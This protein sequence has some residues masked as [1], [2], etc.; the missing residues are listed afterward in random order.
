MLDLCHE[1]LKIGNTAANNKE[2]RDDRFSTNRCAMAQ[3]LTEDQMKT[4]EV[5]LPPVDAILFI[6]E[7]CLPVANLTSDFPLKRNKSIV[8]YRDAPK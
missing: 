8:N 4:K 7:T 6:S 1:S 5:V 2:E 3:P